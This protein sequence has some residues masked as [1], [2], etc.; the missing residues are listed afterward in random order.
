MK[1]R[2]SQPSNNKYYIRQ[3]TGGL[4]GAVAGQP[5][6]KGANVLCNCVGFANGRY[7]EIIN[8]GNLEGI[9][10]PFKY[11][12]VCNAEDFIESAKRQGLSISRTPIEGGIMVWAKGRAGV[13]S[14]G[15]GHVAVVEQVYDDGTILTSESGWNAWA[16]KTVRRGNANGRWGQNSAYSFR[17]CIINP[18]VTNPK[19]VPVPPLVVDGIGGEATVMAMQHF[20]GTQ[21]DGI[22]S[23]QIKA[24]HKAYFPAFTAVSYSGGKSTC[25]VALQKWL[26]VSADGVIG[27]ATVKAWQRRLGVKDDGVFGADSMR[28]WQTFL[29][30]NKEPT[31]TPEPTPPEPTPEPTPTGKLVEDGIGG[32][33]TVETTQRFFGT[34]VDGVITGQVKAQKYY[35][36]SLTAVKFNKVKSTC[37]MKLQEWVGVKQDGILGRDTCLAWQGKLLAMGYDIGRWGA[38]GIFGTESMRAWQKFLN[39]NEPTP[40]TPTPTDH[41]LMIDVSEFQSSI[42]FAKVKADGIKAVI[43][44][45]G[46]RGGE[47]GKIYED[48]KFMEY[49]KGAHAVGLPVGIYFLTAAINAQEGKEEAEYTI[50][51]WKKAGV[52]IS[53]P[54]CIDTEDIKWKNKDG[55]TGYGRANSNK[56]STAKRTEAVKA[57]GEECKRQGYSSMIYASTSWLNNQLD[58]SQ[59]SF[60]DVW[61][62][63]YYKECQYKGK[64]IIWQYTSEG[65]VNGVKGGTNDDVDMDKCYV[66]PKPVN[67][68]SPTPTPTPSHYDGK[69]PSISQI[70]KSSHKGMIKRG[71]VWAHRVAE[72]KLHYVKYATSKVCQMCKGKIVWDGKKFV[73]YCDYDKAGWQCIGTASAFWHHG[74]GTPTKCS[75]DVVAQ[76]KNGHLDLYDAKTDA[77]ALKMAQE[78]FGTKDIELIR[79]KSN[80]PKSK[81]KV[82]DYCCMFKNGNQFQH[83]FIVAEDGQ[84]FDATQAGGIGSKNN[85]KFRSNKN[86]SCKVIIRYTG[87]LSYLQNGDEGEA[88]LLT[89]KFLNWY[90][91]TFCGGYGLDEDGIFGN[92]TEGAVKDFQSKNG[93]KVDGFVGVDT[94]SKMKEV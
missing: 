24:L 87:G 79:S 11:Q 65:K 69:L 1:I 86:Y 2:T 89:Q 73:I 67:P 64:Y 9:V 5:T 74:M 56:L 36:P 57:F 42:D 84:V 3:A 50:S 52:P 75:P 35:Y 19:V 25:V 43:V 63:Q 58:M 88:V 37:I 20:F 33:A 71:L 77:I 7:N 38:D 13:G 55:S 82:G 47:S 91:A 34:L 29:N 23:S 78:K 39:G 70:K 76:G 59:L 80:I 49:I 60:M 85:I 8:D 83:A 4:N 12:L 53:Y 44:R 6:I 68:P 61:C 10:K 30:D 22:I 32:K 16:F 66:E 46:G 41:Y 40:P 27:Q 26:G 21:E 51:Q 81:W 45:C 18:S 72:S 48:T 54:I 93:L 17:G 62:A 92:A 15:A 90:G 28:A 94:L 14:D 31:P